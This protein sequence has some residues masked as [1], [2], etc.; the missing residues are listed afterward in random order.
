MLLIDFYNTASTSH[1]S[2]QTSYLYISRINELLL[3]DWATIVFL[4]LT[5]GLHWATI[6]LERATFCFTLGYAGLPFSAEYEAHACFDK[7]RKCIETKDYIANN[8]EKH[9]GLF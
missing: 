1:L 9:L 4:L 6:V 8:L 5:T 7:K 2:A 3:L